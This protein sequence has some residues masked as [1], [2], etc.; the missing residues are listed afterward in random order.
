[1]TFAGHWWTIPE[2]RL[3][4]YYATKEHLSAARTVV[5]LR[6]LHSISTTRNALTA[7]AHRNGF[8]FHGES[9]KLGNLSRLGKKVP[10]RKTKAKGVYQIQKGGWQVCLSMN[11]KR[12]YL[13]FFMDRAEAQA[14]WEETLC[15]L[16]PAGAEGPSESGAVQQ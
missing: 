16:P 11:G 2:I 14:V 12:I 13:G 10:W 8:H 6:E 9:G 4:R 1:M 3:V 7:L 15:V 5:A